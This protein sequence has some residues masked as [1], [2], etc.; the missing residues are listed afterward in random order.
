VRLDDAVR[1]KTGSRRSF[2][3]QPRRNYGVAS[4][5]GTAPYAAALG[6]LAGDVDQPVP[7]QNF[8]NAHR[9]HRAISSQPGSVSIPFLSCN[10]EQTRDG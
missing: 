3:N 9:F 4:G 5:G 10:S 6:V 1:K 2:K 8:S 7:C